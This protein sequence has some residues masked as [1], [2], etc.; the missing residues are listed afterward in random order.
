MNQDPVPRRPSTAVLPP[1]GPGLRALT[2][3][4]T[5]VVVICVLYFGRAVLIPII[6]AVLLSFLVAPFVDLLRP[7]KFVHRPGG[8]AGGAGRG[9]FIADPR[10]GGTHGRGA[11]GG[12]LHFVAGGSLARPAD[13]AVRV[14]RPAARA[15]RHGRSRSPAVPLL[16]RATWHQHGR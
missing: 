7:L 4:I 11:G 12:H 2:S 8:V 15:H 14:A 9:F 10:S 13:G 3:L 1:E 5:G 16:P 6:L